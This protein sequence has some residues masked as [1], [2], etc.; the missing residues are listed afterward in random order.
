MEDMFAAI[1]YDKINT[2]LYDDFRESVLTF[3][4]KR[5]IL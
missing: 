2:T 5:N 1:L 4:Y 3:I